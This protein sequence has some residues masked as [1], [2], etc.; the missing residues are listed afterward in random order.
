MS[1]QKR[2]PYLPYMV[3]IYVGGFPYQVKVKPATTHE[4]Y[5]RETKHCEDGEPGECAACANSIAG[6][7]A[8]VAPYLAFSDSR[9]V[10]VYK[11]VKI[12]KGGGII[13]IGKIWEHKQGEFQKRYDTDKAAL[14]K[15]DEAIGE[16]HLYPYRQGRRPMGSR[17][18]LRGYD[19][20]QGVRTF[21]ESPKSKKGSL[22]RAQRSG[23]FPRS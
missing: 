21:K 2:S 17:S 20:T 9:V 23:L 1:K 8:G 14:L 11:F 6:M 5:L 15:S 13:G 7:A 18:K 4:K 16:V 3:K 19:E 22:R 10:G 12:K